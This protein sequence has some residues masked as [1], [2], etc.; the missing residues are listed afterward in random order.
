MILIYNGLFYSYSH[1]AIQKIGFHYVTKENSWTTVIIFVCLF[2]DMII[3]PLF[4]GMNL[5]EFLDIETFENMSIFK[6]KHTDFG[7]NWYKDIGY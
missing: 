3:L 4:I 5:V 2:C 7:P 1:W 6:G